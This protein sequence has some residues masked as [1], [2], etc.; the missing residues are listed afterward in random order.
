MLPSVPPRFPIS[1]ALANNKLDWQFFLDMDDLEI[2]RPACDG[3]KT[4]VDVACSICLGVYDEQD[5]TTTRRRRTTKMA[6]HRHISGPGCKRNRCT[7]QPRKEDDADNDDEV[8]DNSGAAVLH[9]GDDDIPGD[10]ELLGLDELN[11]EIM[12]RALVTRSISLHSEEAKTV[13]ARA[14][15]DKEINNLTS[16]GVWF[17]QS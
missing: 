1:K 6:D 13:E 9:I 11:A 4:N 17:G 10:G 15:V 2:Q 8:D 16:M 5:T 7:C 3:W 12:A 14:A